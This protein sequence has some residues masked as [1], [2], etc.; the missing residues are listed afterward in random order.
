MAVLEHELANTPQQ[1][2][3]QPTADAIPSSLRR[4]AGSPDQVFVI[5]LIGSIVLAL[6]ASR[7]LASWAERLSGGPFTE[8]AQ[9]FA[10]R[11]DQTMAALG[12][13]LPHDTLRSAA[14]RFL[15]CQWDGGP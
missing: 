6:F 5:A 8:Q 4:G 7:D 1:P 14:A 2:T 15:E 10:A 12:F 9:S 11:W 13:T 3:A